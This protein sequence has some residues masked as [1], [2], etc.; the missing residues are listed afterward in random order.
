MSECTLTN[1]TAVH[2]CQDECWS[3]SELLSPSYKLLYVQ[4]QTLIETVQIILITNVLFSQPFL[5]VRW[6]VTM[7]DF[8]LFMKN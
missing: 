2:A 1:R 5:E 8:Y 7:N 6:T 3:N 4:L